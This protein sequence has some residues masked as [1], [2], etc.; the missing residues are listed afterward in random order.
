MPFKDSLT[1]S[2]RS[3]IK[4][5][6]EQMGLFFCVCCL[7]RKETCKKY[8]DKTRS[9]IG[10]TVRRFS[11]RCRNLLHPSSIVKINKNIF[12]RNKNL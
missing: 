4:K 8:G 11:E 6:F 9:I 5:G 2:A 10:T 3:S 7:N 12:M 1:F